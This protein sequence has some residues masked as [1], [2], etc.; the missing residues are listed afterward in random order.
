MIFK[1]LKI[2]MMKFSLNNLNNKIINRNKK[3]NLVQQVIKI[4]INLKN[5]LK[6]LHNKIYINNNKDN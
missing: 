1:K 3:E 5:S 4:I 6:R 2:K